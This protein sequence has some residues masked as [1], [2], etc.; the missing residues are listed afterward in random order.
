M[1]GYI[2]LFD[3]KL[4]ES[5]AEFATALRVN[6]NHADAWMY[7]ADLKVTEGRAAEALDCVNRALRLNPHSPDIYFWCWDMSYTRSGAMRMQ[8]R[9]CAN[10]HP[11]Q[12]LSAP[13]QRASRS[14]GDSRKRRR[15]GEFYGY[16]PRIFRST[17]G[18]CD[19]VS[20]RDGPA[21]LYRRVP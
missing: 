15:K 10:G 8:S 18:R 20:T 21:A 1:L 6:P 3:S 17:L 4:D 2:L 12:Y 5:A 19:A 9:H 14:S 11:L 7:M 13:W 16:E